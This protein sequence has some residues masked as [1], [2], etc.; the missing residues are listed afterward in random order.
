MG[1]QAEPGNCPLMATGLLLLLRVLLG[2]NGVE[3]EG[4][5][6]EKIYSEGKSTVDVYWLFCY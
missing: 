1:E 4:A 3:R 2:R 5:G 6:E